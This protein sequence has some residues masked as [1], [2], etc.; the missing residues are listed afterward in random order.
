MTHP[1]IPCGLYLVTP[2]WNDTAKLVSTTA[3]AI[4]GGAVCLQYRNKTASSE[5]K[6]QQIQQLRQLCHQTK[7]PFIINDDLYSAQ[8]HADGVHLG[9]TDGDF[10]RL[11]R[12]KSEQF[13]VGVSCYGDFERAKAAVN[14]GANYIAFGAMYTS[15][16]KPEAPRAPIELITQAK[17]LKTTIACIGGITVQNAPPL[18]QAGAHLLA[19]ISD[20]YEA[21]DPAERAYQFA[22]LFKTQ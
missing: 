14:A 8:S 12:E 20:V 15:P 17:A 19:V 18:I 3:A 16:T 4:E 11:C 9:R 2:N 10:V 22:Q 5:L 1:H 13:I 7:T 21:P 6:D